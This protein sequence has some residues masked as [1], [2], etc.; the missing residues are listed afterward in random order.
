MRD[1]Q[2]DPLYIRL[3][4]AQQCFRA[5]LT[6]K[7]WRIGVPGR[8]PA[9][10]YLPRDAASLTRWKAAY[11]RQAA[12]YATCALLAEMGPRTVHPDLAP[13]IALHDRA[14]RIDSGLPLA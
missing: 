7:P 4:G 5:R 9:F 2:A 6:P 14:T 12:G 8:P 1:L 13:V 3:C 11:E 10:P